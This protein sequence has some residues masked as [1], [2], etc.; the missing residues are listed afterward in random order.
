M[1]FVAIDFETAV[2]QES[3]CAVGIV[4]VDNGVVVDEYCQLIQPPDNQYTWH[5]TKVHGLT[6]KDTANSPTFVDVYPEIMKRVQGKIVVAHNEKFD[7]SVLQKTMHR[8]GLDYGELGLADKWECTVSVFRKK[9]F[10]PCDLATLSRQHD[11]TLDHH[12]A[13]SDARAC[14]QLYLR[15]L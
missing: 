2:G 1:D 4:T 10:H 8:C 9:G 5:T 7:R 12:E 13:L 6:A 3:P 15:S 14:A 11:I